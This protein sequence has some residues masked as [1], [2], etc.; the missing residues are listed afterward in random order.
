MRWK[1]A[2]LLRLQQTSPL[3]RP[4]VW[5][6]DSRPSHMSKGRNTGN[7]EG[8]PL[9]FLASQGGFVPWCTARCPGQG[10]FETWIRNLPCEFETRPLNAR[11]GL[12]TRLFEFE[13]WHP[14]LNR[15]A[16]SETSTVCS[17]STLRA[18]NSA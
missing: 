11:L 1:E 5:G 13:T 15:R 17:N 3:S 10:G 18:S 2:V 6:L 14:N 9:R 8:A 4:R 16:E 7:E 12:K